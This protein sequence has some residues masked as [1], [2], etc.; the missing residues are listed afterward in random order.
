[1]QK[2]ITDERMYEAGML[3][4]ALR[5]RTSRRGF[6]RCLREVTEELRLDPEGFRSYVNQHFAEVVATA[7]PAGQRR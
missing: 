6:E 7:R 4:I 2:T 5:M 1:L 3:R